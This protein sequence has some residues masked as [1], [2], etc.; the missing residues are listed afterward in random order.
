MTLGARAMVL[1]KA[2]RVLLVRHTYTKGLY[3]P[4]G[5]VERGETVLTS[6]GRELEEEAGLRLTGSA[7]LVGVFSNHR[8]MK[9]DHVCLYKIQA[10]AWEDTGT[11]PIGREI[12]ELVWCDPANPPSDATPGTKRRLHE[13]NMGDHPSEHW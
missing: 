13:H 12:S 9:N 6:L 10:P 2:G 11:S 4:G 8:I 1:D 5:G 3:L 7:D